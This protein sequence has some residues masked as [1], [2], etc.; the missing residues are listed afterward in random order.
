MNKQTCGAL[1]FC[2]NGKFLFFFQKGAFQ[3]GN[4]QSKES[5][6]SGEKQGQHQAEELNAT[7]RNNGNNT[8][9]SS[10]ALT[11]SSASAGYKEGHKSG[12]GSSSVSQQRMTGETSTRGRDYF[13]SFLNA[14]SSFQ[15]TSACLFWALS[16]WII[17]TR[18][19]KGH[20]KLHSFVDML[21]K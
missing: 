10:K 11:S 16:P 8:R 3:R 20:R 17:L 12:S 14:L 9:S 18:K 2:I 6:G 4:Q 19:S 5:S 13:A 7:S 15:K 1:P 21:L